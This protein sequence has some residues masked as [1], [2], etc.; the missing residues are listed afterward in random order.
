MFGYNSYSNTCARLVSHSWLIPP[1]PTVNVDTIFYL[2][3]LF[4][5]YIAQC[6]LYTPTYDMSTHY[7]TNTILHEFLL[8]VLI[9][10]G[11]VFKLVGVFAYLH[12]L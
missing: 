9:M 7:I 12:D 10:F 6:F 8:I 3:L 4:S 2:S 1:P 11:L 5:T